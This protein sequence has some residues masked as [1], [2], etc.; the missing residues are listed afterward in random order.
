MGARWEVVVIKRLPVPRPTSKQHEQVSSLATA[1]HDAKA[2]WDEGN[3]VSTRF[4]VPWLIRNDLVESGIP[5]ANRL[6][7]LKTQEAAEDGRIQKLYAELNEAVYGLYGISGTPRMIIERDLGNRPTEVIWPQTAAKTIQQKRMEHVF[8]L[9]TYLVMQVM[10]ADKDGIVPFAPVSGEASLVER[11]VRELQRLF[12]NHDVAQVEIEIANE[13]KKNVKGY[14][15]SSNIAEWL[16]NAF[17][18]YHSSLYR[19][20][21]IFWHVASTKGTERFAFGALVDYHHFDRNRLAK[22]RGQYLRDAM[23]TFR[24]EAALADK[25]GRTDLRIEWQSRLE[26]AQELDRRLQWIQEGR[27]EGQEGGDND[28]RILTPWKSAD[29]RPKGWD[30]DLDD[31]VKVNIQPF[32]KAGVLRI[33]KVV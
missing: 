18:E 15:R 1:I 30:P 26:E 13:L 19:N 11:I 12:P 5:F 33:A 2:R 22:L 3:E 24:R 25:V 29:Q 20:R 32:Q 4:R 16:E 6:D 17:F 21:P 8:R 7:S 9:L 28:F 10:R 14:C 31:G 27:H 23:D